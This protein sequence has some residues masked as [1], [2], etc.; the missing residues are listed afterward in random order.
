LCT[1]LKFIN[2]KLIP[3]HK[4]WCQA[5]SRKREE[6]TAPMPAMS[7]GLL[8]FFEEE[9]GGIKLRPEIVVGLTILLIIMSILAHMGLFGKLA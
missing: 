8:R 4:Q 6:E 7:A 1:T 3:N 2:V 5:M 9:A